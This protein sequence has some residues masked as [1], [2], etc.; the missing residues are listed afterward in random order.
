MNFPHIVV[1]L[2]AP[3]V[4]DGK[5]NQIRDWANPVGATAAAWV[6]PQGTT[7]QALNQDRVVSRWRI[8]IEPTADIVATDRVSW[9][10]LTFQ[11]D[12]EIQTWDDPRGNAHHREG[13]L[14]RVT[15]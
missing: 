12:G 4:S 15:G 2:R 10:G 11:V 9:N 5:G 3:L 14:R 6:Q 1:I 7:E 8:F 13:L